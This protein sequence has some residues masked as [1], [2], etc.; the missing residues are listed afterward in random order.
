MKRFDSTCVCV[1][2]CLYT[3]ILDSCSDETDQLPKS[4]Y[5]GP[6]VQTCHVIILWVT[7]NI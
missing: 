3:Y 7:Q 2:V 4:N 5:V 6:G 1:C